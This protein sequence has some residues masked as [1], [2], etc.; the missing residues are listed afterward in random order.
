MFP[1]SGAEQLKTS[2]ANG[3]TR[4]MISQSGAYS[5]LVS[6]APYSLSGRNRFHKPAARAVRRGEELDW[7]RLTA[8][9]RDR[10]P[11]SN[12]PGLDVSRDPAIAQFPGGHSNLTYLVRFGDAEIVIRRPPFGPVAPTAHDVAREFRW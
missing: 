9:L 10:L 11:A 8:W 12:I 1:V 3:D 5:T 6:P 7:R 4:P 2:G